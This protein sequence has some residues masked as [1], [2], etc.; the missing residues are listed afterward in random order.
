MRAQICDTC[1][2]GRN[3]SDLIEDTTSVFCCRNWGS[4]KHFSH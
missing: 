2:A 4:S 1:T 3:D